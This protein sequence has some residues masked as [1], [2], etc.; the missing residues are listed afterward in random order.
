MMVKSKMRLNILEI[1][2]SIEKWVAID[3]EKLD[4]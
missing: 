4:F 3:S 2:G 1:I